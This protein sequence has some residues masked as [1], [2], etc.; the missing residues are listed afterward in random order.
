M[1]ADAEIQNQI[2]AQEVFWKNGVIGV[3]KLDV[4]K[5]QE[6]PKG[7]L[8]WDNRDFQEPGPLTKEY[9]SWM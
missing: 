3:S 6:D 7:Q 1:E 5:T 2:R 9:R 8:S 4:S